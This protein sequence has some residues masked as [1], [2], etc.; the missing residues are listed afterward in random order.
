MQVKPIPE[1]EHNMAMFTLAAER[2]ELLY[3]KQRAVELQNIEKQYNDLKITSDERIQELESWKTTQEARIV[4]L[5]A[6]LESAQTNNVEL[7]EKLDKLKTAV[8]EVKDI[9]L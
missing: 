6:L 5:E 4:S 2:Q 9:S 7:R 1:V 3:Y 8:I